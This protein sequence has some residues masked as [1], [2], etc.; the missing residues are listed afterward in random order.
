M[1]PVEPLAGKLLIA[2]PALWDPN[3]RRTVV[4]V[5]HHGDQGAVGVVLNRAT[6]V[7]VEEA[8]PPLRPLVEPEAPLFIG[9]PVQPSA[10]VVLADFEH[11]EVARVIAFGS[12][13]FL[14]DEVEAGEGEGVRRARVFAGHAGWGPGQLE[15]E[16]DEGSW[17]VEPATEDDVFTDEPDRLWERVLRRKGHKFDLL[18][19]MP[20]D[21]A[22]N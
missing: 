3:F 18:R 15:A 8:A 6:E 22:S 5:G 10:A 14:P 21:P 9:G 20:V 19:T 13:G 1:P 16:L 17:I 11:P 7:S 12:I 2:G 4:L